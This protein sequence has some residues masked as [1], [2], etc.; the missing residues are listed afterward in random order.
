MTVVVLILQMG[1]LR[2]REVQCSSQSHTACEWWGQ[3][4]SYQATRSAGGGVLAVVQQVKDLALPQM[5]RKKKF[6]E[7]P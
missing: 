7:F 1:K 3:A 4:L 6:L 5:R 2:P